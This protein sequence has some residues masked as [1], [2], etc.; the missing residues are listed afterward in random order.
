MPRKKHSPEVVS[1]AILSSHPLMFRA[2]YEGGVAAYSPPA[3]T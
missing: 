2:C 1:V 3:G